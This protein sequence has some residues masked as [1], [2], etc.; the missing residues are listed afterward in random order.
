MVAVGIEDGVLAG[1]QFLLVLLRD[2]ADHQPAGELLLFL[3]GGEGGERNFSD[4]S[5]GYPLAGGLIE[6]RILVLDL[7]PRGLVDGGDGLFD[8]LI[9]RTVTEISAPARR[10]AA[11][12]FAP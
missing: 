8:F 7:L 3:F 9:Q 12:T 1:G 5:L 10:A 11:A 4:L 6:D 2:S